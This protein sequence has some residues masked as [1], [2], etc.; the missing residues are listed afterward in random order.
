MI[1]NDVARRGREVF[2]GDV[3]GLRAVAVS[4]V[5]LYHLWPTALPGGYVGVDVFFV[6][7]GFL[8]TGNLLRAH[9]R[10]GRVRLLDFWGR[11][12]RRL[13]PAAVVVLVV[14]WL[15][16]RLVLPATQL[17]ATAEQIRA[18]ALYF[19]NWVLARDS[20]DYLQADGAASPVQHFWSL[21]VEEQFYLGWPLLFLAAGGIGALI[22][23]AGG[24]RRTGGRGVLV[25][26]AA[27]VVTASLWYS[28]HE[29]A[30]NPAAAYFVTPTRVWELALGGLLALAPAR[31]MRAA[32]RVGPLAWLGLAMI[33]GSAMLVSGTSPFPGWLALVPVLGAALVLVAGGADARLGPARLTSL[34]P[35]VF[36]G[37]VS[38]SLYLWHWPAIVLWRAWSGHAVGLVDGLVLIAVSVG[39]A[40][41]TKR[42]VEDPVRRARL[43]VRSPFRSLSMATAALLPVVL[44]S[45]WLGGQS[46]ST[47]SLDATHPGAAALTSS[48]TTLSSAS[49]VPSLAQLTKDTPTGM[50]ASCEADKTTSTVQTCTLGDT[51][52]PQLTVA[53]VGDSHAAQWSDALDKIA[54]AHHWKLV[55]ATKS[56]CPF[57]ATEVTTPGQQT[58]YASCNT[59]NA[60]LLTSLLTDI[61]P[62]VVITSDRSYNAVLPSTTADAASLTKIG[63]GMATYWKRLEAAGIGVVA[64][65]E[66]P[67]PGSNLADCLASRT[68][69]ASSCTASRSASFSS[70]SPV[71]VAAKQLNGAVP[72]IDLTSL[73]CTDTTCPGAVG[74][75][76][77][78]L[79]N[80]HLTSTYTLSLAPYL[81]R[82]LLTKSEDFASRT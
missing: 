69:S 47:G 80:H 30:A 60:A 4:L 5:V 9:E 38:Y 65:H 33:G 29:T 45:V 6:V 74:N 17:A 61:E 28:V 32:G 56:G 43:V 20:V 51:T 22:R 26:L 21:S 48:V 39:L 15:T 3:Q 24:R 16:S 44:V 40:T 31:A 41:L 70:V 11:R 75:V 66:T 58:A 50:T 23:R 52:D 36:L 57:T 68:G 53:L 55:V 64:I 13:L 59:W 12:A 1:D 78:Y 8:I 35:M 18:S 76:V 42:F 67:E 46:A 62:D 37:G 7:S 77:V 10:D 63:N 54:K 25:L 79:D 27:G 49:Y 19:Q 34:R 81:E 82:A 71:T 2:R 73:I 72:V 14:T